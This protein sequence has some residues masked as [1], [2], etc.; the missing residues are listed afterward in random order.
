MSFGSALDTNPLVL[1]SVSLLFG[2][3]HMQE[4]QS[5]DEVLKERSQ[6]DELRAQLQQEQQA[7]RAKDQQ[8]Q[9]HIAQSAN[10]MQVRSASADN[11]SVLAASQPGWTVDMPK[12][13][14][15]SS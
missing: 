15:C 5:I 12:T 1:M 8:L 3:A 6:L 14:F 11:A 4:V 2:G 13:C 7:S 10:E 9:A